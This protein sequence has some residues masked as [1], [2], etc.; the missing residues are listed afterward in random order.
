MCGSVI[1]TTTNSIRGV[2]R[3]VARGVGYVFQRLYRCG[4]WPTGRALGLHFDTAPKSNHGQGPV[5]ARDQPH[6]PMQGDSLLT[7]GGPD[8]KY[9]LPL[10]PAAA[11]CPVKTVGTT[12][13]Q[14]TCE[15]HSFGLWWNQS[16]S[17][18]ALARNFPDVGVGGGVC[19]CASTVCVRHGW[20][21]AAPCAGQ[22]WCVHFM[23]LCH[24][25]TA[26][27]SSPTLHHS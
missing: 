25:C 17:S 2:A 12:C 27:H 22:G 15:S 5:C 3:G 10:V 26:N 23:I 11:S 16:L 21:D 1:F 19:V 9:Q 14:Q 4:V 6:T 8:R 18:E 24:S 13:S 20:Y 7:K